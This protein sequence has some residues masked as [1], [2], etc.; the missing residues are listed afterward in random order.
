MNIKTN[1][2]E[3]ISKAK[4]NNSAESLGAGKPEKLKLFVCF[5][6]VHI[7]GR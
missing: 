4:T 6:Q 5:I 1:D 3:R 7:G 2:L